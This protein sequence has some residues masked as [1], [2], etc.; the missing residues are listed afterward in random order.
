MKKIILGLGVIAT[1]LMSCSDDSETYNPVTPPGSTGILV[2]TVSYTS[3]TDEYSENVLYTYNGNKIVKGGYEDGSEEVYTYNGD[4]IT[5][6]EII[7]GG[8]AVTYSETFTYDGNNRLVTYVV[9]EMGFTDTETFVYNGDGTVTATQ[10]GGFGFSTLHFENDELVKIVN[11]LGTTYEYTYDA[12]NSPFR[13]V[14]GFNKIAFVVHGDHEFFGAKQN[15]T[16]IHETSEDVD[17]M[18]NT[19]TY[20]AS[21]YPTS[22]N[23]EAMFEFG[24]PSS[25]TVQYTYY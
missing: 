2:K 7:E 4:L 17:Y 16:A 6:I 13:N 15:I 19:T 21:N 18:T 25:A 12:K 1:L 8:D 22:V 10:S 24:T 9:E 3:I 5:K 23:S 14:T 20:N 11:S